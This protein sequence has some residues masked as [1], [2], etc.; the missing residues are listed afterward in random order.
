[1]KQLITLILISVSL[2]SYCQILNR[3]STT[4]V[5]NPVGVNDEV[6]PLVGDHIKLLTP[7]DTAK[8]QQAFRWGDH[9]LSGYLTIEQDADPL[10]EIQD[11]SEVNAVNPIGGVN[12]AQASIDSLNSRIN[13]LNLSGG[14]DGVVT[15][16][17]WDESSRM[18]TV[19]GQNGGASAMFQ[20]LDDVGLT[21][22]QVAAMIADSL[23]NYVS[24][25]STINW[26][27]NNTDDLQL[28]T[29]AGTALEG[30]TD[31]TPDDLSDNVVN[32]LS[33]VSGVPST[34]QVLKWNGTNWI[35]ANDEVGGTGSTNVI[36]DGMTITGTGVIGD[37]LQVA[38]IEITG[39]QSLFGDL[40]SL[41]MTEFANVNINGTPVTYTDLLN[42]TDEGN[43]TVSF[44]NGGAW[45]TEGA[46]TNENIIG[47]GFI[48]YTI[49]SE[50]EQ[51][52]IG[53]SYTNGGNNFDDYD[54]GA[55][56][57]NLNRLWIYESGALVDNTSNFSVGDVFRIQVSG[58]TVSYTLNGTTIYVSNTPVNTTSSIATIPYEDIG[59]YLQLTP[60]GDISSTN[61]LQSISKVA[62]TVILSGGGGN[63]TDDVLTEAEVDAFAS[64]NGYL[65]SETDGSTTNE[66]QSL[67][68]TSSGTNRTININNGSG[69][70]FSIADND[71]SA[72]NELQDFD[73]AQLSNN[74]LQLSLTND[75]TIHN[76]D[77]SSLD[78]GTGSS[79]NN[80]IITLQKDGTNIGSFTTDQSFNETISFIDN[81]TQLTTEQV[82]DIV[83][84][85]VI[86]NTETNISVIYDD[87]SNELDFVAAGGGTGTVPNNSTITLQR[88]GI[89][90]GSFTTDQSFNESFNFIDSNTQLS[91]EE[92][93]D[94]IGTMLAGNTESGI[95]VTYDD[96]G[97]EIDFVVS[98]GGTGSANNSTITLQKD[99]I[100]IG[101][102]TTDQSFNEI[103]SFTDNNTQL[104]SEE[105]QDIIGTMVSGN[106]E[107]GITVTYD[108]TGNELDFNV[109]GGSTADGDGIYDGNG[110][111]NGT[112]ASIGSS[113]M[114]WFGTITG[115]SSFD[116][117]NLYVRG[118]R[119][120]EFFSTN[121]ISVSTPT[122]TT[123]GWD[124]V[125]YRGSTSWLLNDGTTIVGGQGALYLNTPR[126]YSGLAST[127][128]VLTRQ[129]NGSVEFQTPS[130]GSD[131]NGIYSGG[132]SILDGTISSLNGEY[133]LGNTSSGL[134]LNN[135]T[136]QTVLAASNSLVLFGNGNLITSDADGVEIRLQNSAKDLILTGISNISEPYHLV[137]NPTTRHVNYSTGISSDKRL[138]SNIRQSKY[139]L[140]DIIQLGV[141][142]YKHERYQKEKT[143]LIAQ[144]LKEIIPE[145]VNIDSDG[146]YTI[147][148]EV[149]TPI[150]IKTIQKLNERIEKLE[151]K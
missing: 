52:A 123:T 88:N 104:T 18:F 143:G 101:A 35:P 29:T 44:V 116:L 107:S 76:V 87:V 69:T 142:D 100:N 124:G 73:I 111:I 102:F 31:L 48:E 24:I 1:M 77:L 19:V 128:Q 63:F 22:N 113:D 14:A 103:I 135:S 59:N 67:S 94:A 2:H 11:A 70:T 79:A 125:G 37:S 98:G 80:S 78:G 148:Y 28:G 82:Q 97:N 132:G 131:G 51:G 16:I 49:Q 138:K 5:L 65:T 141:Y 20:I 74:T 8:F 23:A 30:N 17:S 72:T 7:Q 66:L 133:E 118:W 136:D 90:V 105:V 117:E 84:S 114:R 150:L 3:D 55:R 145:A 81:N 53:L 99:G 137:Y 140:E 43:G 93:Q 54:Y 33:N 122:S 83:G 95:T 68:N 50:T 32:D 47:N 151:N 92:V 60:D 58:A 46:F 13:S 56:I 126:H 149:I 64:N 106:T 42:A 96:A 39:T 127:G 62:G 119:N 86:G 108:D 134:F 115:G 15:S 130:N 110:T 12:T 21:G 27:K 34:N 57:L 9:S 41:T 109:S 91:T 85:M 71:N 10:N 144:E 146:Y 40:S 112:L 121:Q 120:G 61:E 89:N 36:A 4:G 45:G 26:D 139:G 38:D 129:A 147:S 75:A 6:D 25:S